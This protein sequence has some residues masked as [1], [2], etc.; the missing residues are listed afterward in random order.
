MKPIPLIMLNVLLLTAG[1]VLWKIGL[2]QAG[3]FTL[4]N[5]VKVLFSPLI[6]AGLFIYVIA[7]GVWFIVLGKTD[8]SFAY[9][10][11]SMA[12]ILGVVAALLIFK[13]VIPPSRW[14]GVGVIIL[15]VYLVSMK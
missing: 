5:A 4:D 14:V 13:E 2:N 8:L 12:Y 6:L 1:Q 10:L 7:T 9:P 11:Q 15:G 3:G